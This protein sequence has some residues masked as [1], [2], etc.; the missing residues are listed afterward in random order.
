MK[1][2][3]TRVIAAIE[4]IKPLFSS[5][6]KRS[7]SDK[8]MILF[9]ISFFIWLSFFDEDNFC[10]RFSMW[11]EIKSLESDRQE[12]LEEIESSQAKLERLHSDVETLERY[13]REEYL[14]RKKDEDIF[15]IE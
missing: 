4:A 15:I 12:L 13:A 7:N 9:S 2:R 10:R 5:F 3:S 14:L 8:F 1:F 11:N 6:I